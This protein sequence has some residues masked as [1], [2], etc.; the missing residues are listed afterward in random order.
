MRIT[1]VH[2][3]TI[4]KWLRSTDAVRQVLV[5]TGSEHMKVHVYLKGKKLCPKQSLSHYGVKNGSH[6]VIGMFVR[7]HSHISSV[8]TPDA[9]WR[10]RDRTI[11][12]KVH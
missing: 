10:Y 2:K 7:P 4:D 12:H 5:V 9:V 3:R 1:D 8:L 6:L 11:F